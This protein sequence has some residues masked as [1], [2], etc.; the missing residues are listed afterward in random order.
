VRRRF[1]GGRKGSL[2]LKGTG[3]EEGGG[4][5]VLRRGGRN[6]EVG[7]AAGILMRGLPKKRDTSFTTSERTASYKKRKKPVGST[8]REKPK[9]R[10]LDQV[11]RKGSISRKAGGLKSREKGRLHQHQKPPFHAGGKEAPSVWQASP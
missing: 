1:C 8:S 7:E 4:G 6:S 9:S 3:L 10:V 11:K 5:S 2:R